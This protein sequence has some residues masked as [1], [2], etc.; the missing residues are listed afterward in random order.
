MFIQFKPK[1]L[2]KPFKPFFRNFR[3]FSGLVKKYSFNFKQMKSRLQDR[4]TKAGVWGLQ[5]WGVSAEARVSQAHHL[6]LRSQ[7]GP[8][9]VPDEGLLTQVLPRLSQPW[10]A[11]RQQLQP[12]LSL[13]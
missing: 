13:Q 6:G 5:A 7:A 10:E 1:F 3:P 4:D 8:V 11:W 9:G 12:G 2:L